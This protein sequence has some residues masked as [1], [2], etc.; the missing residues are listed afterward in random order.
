MED[1]TKFCH[2]HHYV[3]V[4]CQ[5]GLQIEENGPKETKSQRKRKLVSNTHYAMFGLIETY[6]STPSTSP[7]FSQ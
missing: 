3:A 4:G 2:K 5:S 6:D 1:I 7:T